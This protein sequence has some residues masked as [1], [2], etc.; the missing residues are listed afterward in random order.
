MIERLPSSLSAIR[1]ARRP[2]PRAGVDIGPCVGAW[3]LRVACVAVATGCV[4]L[5]ATPHPVVWTAL[6]PA[7][8]LMAL[9]PGGVGATL[10]VVGVGVLALTSRPDPF[11]ARVFALVA[12][13][14]LAV[15][16]AV[17]ASDLPMR[18]LVERRYLARLAR[19]YAATQAFAQVVALVGAGL[20]TS[21]L[22]SA[23]LP[24]VAGMGLAALA[25]LVVAR[26]GTDG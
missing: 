24:V 25:W 17:A 6:A 15:Q 23:A 16:L 9:R 18:G 5:V 2:L 1:P 22:T 26:I 20:A 11:D 14:H 12:G 21:G 8:A 19:A 3:V 13:V 4:L 7:I 10:F